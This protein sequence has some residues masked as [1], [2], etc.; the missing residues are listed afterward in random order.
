MGMSAFLIFMMTPM[1]IA[2]SDIPIK[3]HQFIMIGWAV[4]GF[5]I[6][7][8]IILKLSKGMQEQEN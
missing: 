4:Y 1:F 7:F 2:L 3:Y 8:F 6:C 5:L